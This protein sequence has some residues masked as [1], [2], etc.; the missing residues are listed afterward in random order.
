MIYVLQ[1]VTTND[2]SVVIGVYDDYD[3]MKE[4]AD[5]WR[6]TYTGHLFYD[7]KVLNQNASWTNDQR[8]I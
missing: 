6:K 8:K 3:Q 4:Q 2:N 5:A 1:Q 7:C